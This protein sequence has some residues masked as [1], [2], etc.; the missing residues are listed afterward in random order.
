MTWLFLASLAIAQPTVDAPATT[1]QGDPTLVASGADS[2]LPAEFGPPGAPVSG[3]AL[4]AILDVT[5]SGLRCPTCQ[6][7]SVSESPANSART[8]KQR[9]RE[10][11]AAGYSREQVEA[12]FVSRYG[13]WV[14][15]EPPARGLTWALWVLPAGGVGG[16]F[17]WALAV[18]LRWRE[19]DKIEG[20]TDEFMMPRD[21]YERRILEEIE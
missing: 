4:E 17:A 14:L 21:E 16:I 19:E 3:D 9:I 1:T 10:L 8:M 15:L 18:G 2:T 5:A 11:L 6:G 12:Y 7:L 13:E 20:P